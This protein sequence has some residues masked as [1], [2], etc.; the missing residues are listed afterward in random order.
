MPKKLKNVLPKK[1]E[2]VEVEVPS[3]PPGESPRLKL[4]RTSLQFSRDD[5]NQLKDKLNEVID[6]LN[7][8]E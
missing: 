6:Y 3:N 5:L 8:I 4:G 2:T 7:A 1:T